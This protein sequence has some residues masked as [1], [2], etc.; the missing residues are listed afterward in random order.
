MCECWFVV[1]IVV[2]FVCYFGDDFFG[3]CV[4]GVGDDDEWCVWFVDGD[5]YVYGCFVVGFFG[6]FFD[7]VCVEVWDCIDVLC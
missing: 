1:V 2:E 6:G 7:F 3:G 5:E 4:V